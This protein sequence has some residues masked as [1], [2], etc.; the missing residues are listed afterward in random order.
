MPKLYIGKGHRIID[1]NLQ[2]IAMYMVGLEQQLYAH[3]V[4]GVCALESSRC[5]F[6]PSLYISIHLYMQIHCGYLRVTVICRYIVH[7]VCDFGTWIW[8]RLAS[9]SA[10]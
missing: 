3:S 2:S 7:T 9:S 1:Y 10:W 6:V 4:H 5:Y 8:Y